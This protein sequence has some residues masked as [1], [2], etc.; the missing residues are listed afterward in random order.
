MNILLIENNSAS[1]SSLEKQIRSL[2][3]QVTTSG[4]AEAALEL[5]HGIA[6]GDKGEFT[7][8]SAKGVRQVKIGLSKKDGVIN[9]SSMIVEW[10]AK[11]LNIQN[12]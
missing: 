3:H 1:Q 7:K 10:K 4:D 2:G 12:M 8:I 11:D 5:I 6:R 9:N